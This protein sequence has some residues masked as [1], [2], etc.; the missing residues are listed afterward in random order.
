MDRGLA[1]LR[2]DVNNPRIYPFRE[3]VARACLRTAAALRA[4]ASESE[5]P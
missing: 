5:N 3:H 2:R 1:A 4:E